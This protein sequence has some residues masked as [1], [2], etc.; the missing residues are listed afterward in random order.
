MGDS[1]AIFISHI[2]GVKGFLDISANF[3]YIQNMPQKF[4]SRMRADRLYKSEYGGRFKALVDEGLRLAADLGHDIPPL[5]Q[6][7]NDPQFMGTYYGPCTKCKMAVRISMEQDE[8]SKGPA[9]AT[10]TTCPGRPWL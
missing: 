3:R 9:L 8:L 5:D 6:W 10:T 1:A 4:G 2:F 7:T